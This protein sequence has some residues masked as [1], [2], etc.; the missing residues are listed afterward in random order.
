VTTER[1]EKWRNNE[2][3][4]RLREMRGR[5]KRFFPLGKFSAD[6][7]VLVYF[8]KATYCYFDSLC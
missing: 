4:K 7:Y 2:V 6:A 1:Q 8:V 5:L 3:K